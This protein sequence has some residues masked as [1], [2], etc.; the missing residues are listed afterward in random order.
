MIPVL[1]LPIDPKKSIIRGD[2]WSGITLDIKNSGVP[3]D[4][5]GATIRINLFHACGTK[6][7]LYSGGGGITITD[8]VNGV[9]QINS[10]NRLDWEIGKHNG[11]CEITYSNT[12]RT[13]YCI[14][15][16]TVTDDITK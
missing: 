4:L 11:D 12:I 14:V 2:T 10:I 13:T 16:V 5:T 7:Q 15:N 6:K 3:I 8:P 9:F 1:N